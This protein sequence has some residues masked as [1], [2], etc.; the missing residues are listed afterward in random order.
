MRTP[1][2]S[3]VSFDDRSTDGQSHAQPI[4][5]GRVKGSEKPAEFVGLDA[6]AGVCVPKTSSALI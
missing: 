6:D 1:D 5:L 3:V 4:R 2:L